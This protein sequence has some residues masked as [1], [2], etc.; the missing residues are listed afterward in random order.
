[1]EARGLPGLYCSACWEHCLPGTY[2]HQPLEVRP[3]TW[4]TELLEP[5]KNVPFIPLR[6]Q[7]VRLNVHFANC[8][9]CDGGGI[10][11]I[12]QYF[13]P[14]FECDLFLGLSRQWLGFQE[15]PRAALPANR[16]VKCNER[17]PNL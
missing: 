2:P 12:C 3:S 14:I 11:P 7:T 15:D 16:K 6:Q 8:N 4:T 1:M 17:Q 13:S 10:L 5:A 9:F